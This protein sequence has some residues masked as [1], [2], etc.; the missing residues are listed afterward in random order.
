VGVGAPQGHHG[1][2]SRCR[3]ASPTPTAAASSFREADGFPGLVVDRYE[4]VLVAQVGT[5]GMQ[6]LRPVLYPLLVDVLRPD[7]QD[8]RGIYE[9]ND[10]PARA[11]EG[12][13]LQKGWWRQRSSR[14]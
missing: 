9:R 11:K 10:A 3:A 5:V 7:G 13:A 4:D 6:R 8:I 12:L 2:A 1:L 14:S